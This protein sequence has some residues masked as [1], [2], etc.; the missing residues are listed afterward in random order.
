MLSKLPSVFPVM[1]A[2]T[3]LK[4]QDALFCIPKYVL[5][6]R[7]AVLEYVPDVLSAA[8]ISAQ[9]T[10]SER[11]I[12]ARHRKFD[13]HGKPF[14]IET[15]QFR[16]LLDT[17]AQSKN[18]SQSL[19]AFWAGRSDI[20]HNDW[21]NH[22][23]HE[24]RLEAF[25]SLSAAVPEPQLI[26]PIALAVEQDKSNFKLSSAETIKVHLGSMHVTNFGICIHDYAAT[27][28]PLDKDCIN[29]SES[30]FIKGSDR[31]ISQARIQ[32][33]LLES[34]IEKCEDAVEQGSEGSKKWLGQH[35]AKLVRW[36]QLLEQLTEPKIADGAVISLVE[37]LA[38]Q[39]KIE[40]AHAVRVR[41]G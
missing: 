28:C 30:I 29:C 9:L 20:S 19:I 10:D 17:L 21:Y 16:H 12:F 40:L 18:L 2:A 26:G 15:H 31:H 8:S 37:P 1:D 7:Q 11:S 36:Q 35:Q 32:C 33:R 27:P 22:V 3:G 5:S 39:S 38:A 25:V 34:A 23:S 13:A 14:R 41:K 24:A 4:P 6:Q